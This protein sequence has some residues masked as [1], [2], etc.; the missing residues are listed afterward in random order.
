[1]VSFL[2]RGLKEPAEPEST[3]FKTHP[4]SFSGLLGEN[5]AVD[6]TTVSFG[7]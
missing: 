1:M 2:K 3:I 4:S 7:T 5:R 6:I